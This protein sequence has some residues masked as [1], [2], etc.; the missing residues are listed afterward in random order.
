MMMGHSSEA[1]DFKFIINNQAFEKMLD[2][3]IFTERHELYRTSEDHDFSGKIKKS[4]FRVALGET[5]EEVPIV[6][7]F[8]E[9]PRHFT[10]AIDKRKEVQKGKKLTDSRLFPVTMVHDRRGWKVQIM[11]PKTQNIDR[12]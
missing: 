3:P 2:G 8:A 1:R 12:F 7:T 9:K 5:N 4:T 6:A 10:L 11:L